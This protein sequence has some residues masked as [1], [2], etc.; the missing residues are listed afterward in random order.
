MSAQPLFDG[1]G[2]LFELA[3]ASLEVRFADINQP[4]QAE[5]AVSSEVGQKLIDFL[6]V[7][8]PEI[9]D[10]IQQVAATFQAFT[11]VDLLATKIP[12]VNKSIGDLLASVPKP[13]ELTSTSI[14]GISVM[15]PDGNGVFFTVNVSGVDLVNGGVALGDAVHFSQQT[16]R[17]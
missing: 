3:D 5:I 17:R 15:G 13:L 6:N 9:V 10:G 2:P 14:S 11:S 4:N 12:I 8:I 16:A 1:L 7:D